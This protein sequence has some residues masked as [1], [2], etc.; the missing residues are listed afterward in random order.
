MKKL[1]WIFVA[2]IGFSLGCQAQGKYGS[3]EDSASCRE[4]LYLYDDMIKAKQLDTAY[5]P[6]KKVYEMCPK[7]S[8]NN[9][10]YGPKLVKL[11]IKQASKA[12]NDS[13]KAFY[14]DLLLDVYDKRLVH[15]PGKEGYVLG[16]KAVDM[17]KYHRGTNQEIFD[18][19]MKALEVGGQEQ[20][21]AFYNG[22]FSVSARLFNDKIFSV[23]DVFDSYGVVVEGIEVNNN[24]L[25]TTIAE[26][27]ARTE[28]ST[29]NELTAK[30]QK[31]L[32]KSKRELARYEDVE[33]N[34]NKI[35]GKIATCKILLTVYNE[36]G[37]EANKTN[38]VWLKRASKMLSKE[39]DNEEGV[40]ADCTDNPIFFKVA[41]A[42]YKLEPS[43]QAARAMGILAFKNKEFT[44][45]INYFKEAGSQEI[46]PKKAAKD[47]F[48]IAKLNVK[49]GNLPGAK[50]NILIAASKRKN[51][52]EPYLLLAQ[53]YALSEGKCGSDV[54]EKKAVYWA[55]IDKLNYAKSIDASVSS[56]ANKLIAAY[57]QQ[58]PGKA[59]VFN[60]G[61][62]AGDT[63][64]IG[65]WINETITVVFY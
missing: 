21:A 35:I 58:V 40:E 64:T 15:F 48:T 62:V 65:C 59:I 27:S 24:I 30:E 47:Y 43:I 60:L 7:S 51:W 57:K 63:Y 53:I 54:Y 25:N 61:H 45:S 20:S 28:D 3:E 56:D 14:V 17:M 49:L 2:A 31:R 37:F 41:E 6:W 38:V 23:A 16:L 32:A 5:Y 12:K 22:L 39:R 4:N 9:F 29:A 19:F 10:I 8:K 36:E 26:L 46:D 50:S 55:A 44:K 34:V 1:L 13:L 52:G 18:I 33:S 42:L 11:K